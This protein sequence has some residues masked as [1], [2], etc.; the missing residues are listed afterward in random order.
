MLLALPVELLYHILDYMDWHHQVFLRSVSRTLDL[1]IT[2]RDQFWL[3]V[4][5]SLPKSLDHW[6]P[7]NHRGFQGLHCHSLKHSEKDSLY[8]LICMTE[9]SQTVEKL[10]IGWRGL[11]RKP[12]HYSIQPSVPSIAPQGQYSSLMTDLRSLSRQSVHVRKLKNI[13]RNLA[14][15]TKDDNDSFQTGQVLY[16]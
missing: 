3:S 12:E 5:Q 11:C 2:Y 4:R 10:V 16:G 15:S 1:A 13:Q 7:H 14:K 6:S 9:D 8:R